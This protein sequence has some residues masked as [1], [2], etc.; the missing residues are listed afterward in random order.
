MATASIQHATPQP[1]VNLYSMYTVCFHCNIAFNRERKYSSAPTKTFLKCGLKQI[2]SL[3]N[4]INHK[5]QNTKP[6]ALKAVLLG[7]KLPVYS[8]NIHHII[9]FSKRKCLQHPHSYSQSTKATNK[10][11]KQQY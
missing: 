7:H 5:K 8:K 3:H 9:L 11:D 4:F 2:T 6:T 1:E 10:T